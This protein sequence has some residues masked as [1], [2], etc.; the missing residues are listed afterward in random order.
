MGRSYDEG[1]GVEF[2]VESDEKKAMHF[3]EL[4]AISGDVNARYNIAC[5]LGQ[6]GDKKQA[7]KHA[8]ISASAGHQSSLDEVK[9][10]YNNGDVT[11]DEFERTLRAY[12]ERQDET[13]SEMRDKAAKFW[14]ANFM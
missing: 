6:N 5:T 12:Q 3:Y 2:L 11:K 7:F 4:A 13:K 9:N 1:L 8:L 14:A 10:G